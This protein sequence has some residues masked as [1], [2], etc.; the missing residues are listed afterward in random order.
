MCCH[1]VFIGLTSVRFLSAPLL[2]MKVNACGCYSLSV[3]SAQLTQF[4]D[5][6]N[7]FFLVGWNQWSHHCMPQLIT[8]HNSQPP[9]HPIPQ[10]PTF[11]SLHAPTPNPQLIAYHNSQPPTHHIP[12]LP[13]PNSLHAP[14]PN[15]QLIAYHNSQP[16][17]HHIPQLPTPNSSHTTTLLMVTL[18]HFVLLLLVMLALLQPPKMTF[19]TVVGS[20]EARCSVLVRQSICSFIRMMGKFTKE[21]IEEVTAGD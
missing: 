14:T 11:N 15:P 8:Y 5:S 21:F 20:T 4:E 1:D 2:V 9:T 10:L 6:H 13:T 12:Q 18:K 17:T 19:F 3:N 16:P 7:H